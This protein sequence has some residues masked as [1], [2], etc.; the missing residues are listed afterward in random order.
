MLNDLWETIRYR[1]WSLVPYDYRPGQLWYRLK[2]WAWHRYT[3][4]HPRTL[5]YH[6][7]CDRDVLLLHCCFE[8]LCRFLEDECGTDGVI[9]WDFDEEHKQ[10]M[11]GMRELYRWWKEDYPAIDDE[12]HSK[13]KYEEVNK[14]LHQLINLR[15]YLWT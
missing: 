6:G 7:W 5:N 2:C 4:V 11:A 10:A 8:I 14:R 9:D 1:Y 12:C 13:E 15:K 3:T